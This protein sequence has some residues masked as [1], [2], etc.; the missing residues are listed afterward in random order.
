M[1][2]CLTTGKGNIDLSSTIEPLTYLFYIAILLEVMGRG[3]MCWNTSQM[4]TNYKETVCLPPA[5]HGNKDLTSL[6]IN[7]RRWR[8]DMEKHYPPFLYRSSTN[9]LKYRIRR[10]NIPA[11]R[12]S[13]TTAQITW[14][15]LLQ[16]ISPPGTR[17]CQGYRGSGGI[18]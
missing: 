10:F 4:V 3:L 12:E 15:R 6:G 9:Q 13:T 18:P 16:D 8:E 2:Q 1:I 7:K 11:R 14:G 5:R 17:V